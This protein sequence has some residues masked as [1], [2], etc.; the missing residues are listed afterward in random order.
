MRVL[1]TG[2]TGHL[3]EAL[4]R[5]LPIRGHEP[6]GLDLTTSP[7]TKHVGSIT[8][9]H[10]VR[11][12]L[13]G[14][15]AILHTATLHKPHLATHT[16]Q[17]FIETNIT[18]T[19]VLLEEA[20]RAGLRRFVFTST[21][22]AFGRALNPAA[23]APAAW[24]DETVPSVP[25]NIYGVTKTAAEDL[26]A[27]FAR[28]HGLNAIVL[29]TSRFFLEEDDDKAM[30]DGYGDRNAKANEFL[31]RRI[32][33]EDAALA[34]ECAMLRAT[35]IGFA[36]YV[37]SAPSP[38]SRNDRQRLRQDPAAVVATCHAEF[39][40]IYRKAGFRMFD[41][42]DRIYISDAARTDLGWEPAHDFGS[43]LCQIDRDQP[44]GSDLARAVGK[45]GYHAT[46]FA[47]GPY[48][49]E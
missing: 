40:P 7:F 44:L 12:A 38:F 14:V 16:K 45:K 15:E 22:S 41:D 6:V 9:R 48:P 25:K 19:L 24:I 21:T 42:I 27:L 2:S 4:M 36:K 1:V 32:D 35:D 37:I 18:G 34:H 49:V 43:I 46:T 28:H 13:S 8:D 5:L 31:F 30:R 47:E 17:A 20:A 29:R 26:C 39:E 3:G 10:L 11:R 33:L 23:A